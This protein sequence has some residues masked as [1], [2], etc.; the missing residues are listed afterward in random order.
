MEAEPLDIHLQNIELKN[1]DIHKFD[2][3]RNLDV[4]TYIYWAKSGFKTFKNEIA[5]HIDTEFELNIIQNQDTSFIKHKHFEFH[6]D[7]LFDGITGLL[8]IAPS[9]I[10]MENGD[11]K[12]HG[13]IQTKNEMALD[14]HVNGTKPNF[15]MLIAFAPEDLIPTLELYNNAG[16]FYFHADI[17][18]PIMNGHLPSIY[19]EFGANNA[20][21]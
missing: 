10:K 8:K 7:I 19:A 16:E 1:L 5:A 20:F 12:V 3:A 15:D 17:F 13:S 14:L 18:G 2:E 4:E 6:T 21:L 9:G 11:F